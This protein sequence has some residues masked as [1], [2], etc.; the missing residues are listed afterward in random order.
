MYIKYIICYTENRK[1]ASHLPS[2]MLEIIVWPDYAYKVADS[3][4]STLVNILVFNLPVKKE[5][6]QKCHTLIIPGKTDL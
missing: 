2:Y 1:I 5:V 3:T 6:V 4:V